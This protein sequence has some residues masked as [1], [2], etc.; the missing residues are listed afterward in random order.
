MSQSQSKP[1]KPQSLKVWSAAET[2]ISMLVLKSSCPKS[3]IDC[4]ESQL[5]PITNDDPGTRHK[6]K[7]KPKQ[8]RTQT[9]YNFCLNRSS[10]SKRGFKRSLYLHVDSLSS[11]S[12]FCIQYVSLPTPVH[13][14][15]RL[16]SQPFILLGSFLRGLL[17]GRAFGPFLELDG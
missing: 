4:N 7:Q 3:T 5:R 6:L 13:S 10:L 1:A 8:W 9:I 12:R 17:L 16:P 14:S 11:K 2:T 15:V